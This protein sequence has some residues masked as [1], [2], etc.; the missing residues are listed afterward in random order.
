MSL[1]LPLI[2]SSK[3]ICSPIHCWWEKMI[4][5]SMKALLRKVTVALFSSVV[6]T[7]RLV[8]RKLMKTDVN[9]CGC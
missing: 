2:E 7:I 3:P 4:C 9:F 1:V 5:D 8:T 6:Q